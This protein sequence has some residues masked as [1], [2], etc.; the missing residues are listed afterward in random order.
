MT[1]NTNTNDKSFLVQWGYV[2]RLV[3]SVHDASRDV[4]E[5]VD[6]GYWQGLCRFSSAQEAH[7]F[8]CSLVGADVVA[9]R[10]GSR[11]LYG[12]EEIRGLGSVPLCVV[13]D[14]AWVAPVVNYDEVSF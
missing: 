7:R 6:E 9:E 12:S 2:A 4:W 1:T 5:E 8:A 14:E 3:T 11:T 13:T 10:H